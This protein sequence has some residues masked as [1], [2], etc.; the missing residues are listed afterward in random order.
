[1]SS[2]PTE[3]LVLFVSGEPGPEED[4]S[5]DVSYS[6]LSRLTGTVVPPAML[7]GKGSTAPPVR[8]ARPANEWHVPR[9][10]I[11]TVNLVLEEA[12]EAGCG[13]TLVNVNQPGDQR[14]LVSRWVHPDDILPLLARS[15]GSRLSGMEQFRPTAVRRFVRGE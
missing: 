7:R 8:P 5:R 6:F 2:P 14:D 10:E 1:M 4:L 12:K 11:M 9:A 15:D 13:V 3:V